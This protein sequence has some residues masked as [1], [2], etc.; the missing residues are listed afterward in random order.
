METG[1]LNPKQKTQDDHTENTYINL[2]IMKRLPSS[3]L[4]REPHRDESYKDKYDL[5]PL[6]WK[7]RISY[8]CRTKSKVTTMYKRGL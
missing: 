3:T 7:Y 4:N 5:N 6:L 8:T 2:N 1:T